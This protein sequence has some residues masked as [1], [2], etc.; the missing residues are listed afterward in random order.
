MTYLFLFFEFF[1]IGLFA[2]GGGAATVPFLMEL[3]SKYDWYT[4]AELTNFIA[5][6]ES[7]PGPIGINMATYAGYSAGGVLGGI[8]AVLGLV[9]PSVIIII[10]IAKFLKNFGEYPI[11]KKVFYGIR[12]AVAALIAYAVYGIIRTSLFADS[13]DIT[14]IY[15]YPAIFAAVAF[16]LMFIPRLKRLHPV[17]WIALAAV[18]GIVFRF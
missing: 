4:T 14:T 7:T 5:I 2:I 1:K 18:V 12:P 9:F 16:L 13:G 11:V 17:F 15:V 8:V 3:P 10:L 6:S